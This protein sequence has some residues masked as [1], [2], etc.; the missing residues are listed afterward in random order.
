VVDFSARRARQ[1]SHKAGF[2]SQKALMPSKKAVKSKQK[3]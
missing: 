2:A 3:P 1:V